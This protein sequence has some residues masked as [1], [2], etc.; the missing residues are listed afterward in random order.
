MP[1]LVINDGEEEEDYSRALG[2]VLWRTWPSILAVFGLGC[3]MAPLAYRRQKRFGLPNP[4]AWA[5]FAF[6][7]GLPGWIAYRFHRTWPVLEECPACRQPSPRDRES[8]LDCG[9]AFPPPP[10]KGIEVF[11]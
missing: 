10:M 4:A 11:A 2:I 8:C 3:A 9:K 6:I 5:V 7:F 1:N